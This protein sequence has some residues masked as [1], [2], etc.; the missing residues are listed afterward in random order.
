MKKLLI[1]SSL[2]L[3]SSVMASGFYVGGQVGASSTSMKYKNIATIPSPYYPNKITHDISKSGETGGVY[4][5][6]R[7]DFN[8]L[9]ISGEIDYNIN[10][11]KIEVLNAQVT[12]EPAFGL[13]VL[14]GTAIG[15]NVDIYSRLGFSETEIKTE[16]IRD[17]TGVITKNNQKIH[18]VVLG[19]GMQY[20]F[21]NKLSI[22]LDYKYSM[23]K[24]YDFIYNNRERSF[25]PSIQLLTI[26]IQ[27][28]FI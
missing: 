22:R 1:A 7:I 20:Q 9:F 28:A 19:L 18:G 14:T 4:A 24:K 16:F 27:Y 21:N 8:D 3:S 26:G 13:Y 25:A 23:Y 2:L 17:Q 15:K 10:S 11:S 12:Q 5:G 6:Y